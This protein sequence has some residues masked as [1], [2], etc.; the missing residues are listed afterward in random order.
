MQ[1]RRIPLKYDSIL[2]WAVVMIFSCL[3]LLL[4]VI[5]D[6]EAYPLFT[7]NQSLLQLGVIVGSFIVAITILPTIEIFVRRRH[8][9]SR[10]QELSSKQFDPPRYEDRPAYLLADSVDRLIL[11]LLKYTGGN[12]EVIPDMLYDEAIGGEMSIIE[13]RLAKLS[14]LGLVSVPKKRFQTRIYLTVRGLDALNAPATLFISNIPSGIWE[15][16]FKM[17]M[18]IIEEKW[19]GVAISMSQALELMLKKRLDEART[20]SPEKWDQEVAKTPKF[21]GTELGIGV[22][23]GALCAMEVFERGS[24]E[25]R[26]LDDLNEL[27]KKIH[28]QAD[29]TETQ[30]Y[31]AN[32]AARIDLY[33]DIILQRWY[34]S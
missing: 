22:L 30:P 20:N 14:L 23:I 25:E 13:Q 26:L 6:T 19:D 29:D 31:R 32:L 18:N 28:P 4:L 5:Y 15:Y 7:T 27:R 33:F 1:G 11:E 34:S 3:G 21:A 8:M 9:I 12:F 10:I 17:K 24:F 16:I 2:F